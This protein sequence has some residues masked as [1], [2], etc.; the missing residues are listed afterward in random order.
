[1]SVVTRSPLTK[2]PAL[3]L[4]PPPAPGNNFLQ[5]AAQLLSYAI[6]HP[7]YSLTVCFLIQVTLNSTHRL[8]T[9]NHQSYELCLI[10]NQQQNMQ[11]PRNSYTAPHIPHLTLQHPFPRP[12]PNPILSR[13]WLA[14]AL[15]IDNKTSS[16]CPD[17]P[18]RENHWAQY[19]LTRSYI[20]VLDVLR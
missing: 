1:M 11:Q 7:I 12:K 15:R 16:S 13:P 9:L 10:N 3:L 17:E 20:A 4:P 8:S 2:R 14:Q 18:S 6:L 5:I 19:S